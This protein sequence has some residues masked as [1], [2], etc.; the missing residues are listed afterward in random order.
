MNQMLSENYVS[1]RTYE[2]EKSELENWAKLER[3]DIER[4]QN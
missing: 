3:E 4:T 2:Q 1:P